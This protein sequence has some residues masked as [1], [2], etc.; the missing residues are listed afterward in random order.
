M[1]PIYHTKAVILRSLPVGEANKRYWLFTEELGLVVANAQGV[2]KSSSKL[3]GQ[4]VDYSFIE[5][6]LVKG[7]D[8]WR[9]TSATNAHNPLS[10]SIRAPLARP[11]V[12]ALAT[13]ERFLGGEGEQHSE[14]FNHLEVCANCVIEGNFN[15]QVFDTLA[16]WRVLAHLGYIAVPEDNVGLFSSSFT[17]TFS[18]LDSDTTKKMI[19]EVNEAITYT[20]L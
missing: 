17:D 4:L 3:A 14:L 6:D 13:V 10:G 1:H 16:I 12:R 9:I 20:H 2:R 18:I 19:R 7:R 11:Y 5:V 15:P 8:I